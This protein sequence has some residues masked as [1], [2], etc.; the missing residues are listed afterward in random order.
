MQTEQQS[1][2][3]YRHIREKKRLHDII[4][5][6]YE[7]NVLLPSLEEKKKRLKEIREM[8]KLDFQE[9]VKHEKEYLYK[10]QQFKQRKT[11]NAESERWTYRAPPHSDRIN[12][13]LE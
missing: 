9:L 13:I 2:R 5:E 3:K 4:K 1:N 6:R 11:E 12:M 8:S 10:R 7:S